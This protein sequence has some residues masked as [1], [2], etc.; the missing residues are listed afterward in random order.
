MTDFI[1]PT[2]ADRDALEALDDALGFLTDVERPIVLQAFAKRRL[3]STGV[4][5]PLREHFT[6]MMEAAANYVEPTTYIAR[7]P[8][9][10]L[11]GPC[12][13]TTEFPMP[14]ANHTV[15]A[16]IDI[17]TRRDQA[18]ISDMIYMLDGPEQRAALT[19]TTG[20]STTPISGEEV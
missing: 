6:R 5:V 20:Q 19:P 12:R 4:D 8:H 3:A 10:S 11:I 1:T 2:Q 7:H 18:F 13:F 14:D 17:L 15:S 9:Q 16:K